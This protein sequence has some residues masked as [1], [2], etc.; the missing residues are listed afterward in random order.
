[1]SHLI[2]FNHKNQWFF[3]SFNHEFMFAFDD[4]GFDQNGY[5]YR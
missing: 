2:R 5:P 4:V 3:R 1:M